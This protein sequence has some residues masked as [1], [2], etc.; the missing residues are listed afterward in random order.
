[1]TRLPIVKIAA[2]HASPIFLNADKTTEKALRLIGEAAAQGANLVVFPESYI[3]GFPL[4]ASTG[5]PV[6][7]E[8]CFTRFVEQSIYADGSEIAALQ[9]KAAETKV[10]ISIGFSERSRRSV[11]CVWNSNVVIGE[12]GSILAHHRKMCA[13]YW[14]SWNEFCDVTLSN[15]A[16]GEV[17]ME[18]RRR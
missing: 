11:G 13:T 7:N 18:Q 4:F 3:P 14:V 9:A 5:A 8:G 10:V 12:D 2:C 6:D 1:M 15:L 16:K 17:G